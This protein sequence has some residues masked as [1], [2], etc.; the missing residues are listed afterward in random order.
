MFPPTVRGMEGWEGRPRVGML[1]LYGT[2][3]QA[4]V[5]GMG[6]ELL[7]ALCGTFRQA[8]AEGWLEEKAPE[9]VSTRLAPQAAVGMFL[10]T[11]LG[12]FSKHATLLGMTLVAAAP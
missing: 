6:V 2:F 9:M 8:T 4:A 11:T 7:V 1:A 3:R 5:E 12:N 10:R